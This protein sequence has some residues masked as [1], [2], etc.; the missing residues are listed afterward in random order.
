MKKIAIISIVLCLV[1]VGV[2]SG[3]VD[4]GAPSQPPPDGWWVT[5][6]EDP[7]EDSWI[8]FRDTTYID[9]DIYMHTKFF[10]GKSQPPNDQQWY[11]CI[12]VYRIGGDYSPLEGLC[13]LVPTGDPFPDDNDQYNLDI[14]SYIPS[15]SMTLSDGD[16]TLTF[17][18]CPTPRG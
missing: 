8:W 4:R 12:F 13:I 18:P 2:L 5:E 9:A 14:I 11:T 16:I 15:I 17:S 10:E 7:E 1:S 3:C 6:E